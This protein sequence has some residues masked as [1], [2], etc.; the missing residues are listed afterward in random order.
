MYLNLVSVSRTLD[1]E[2]IEALSL[3]MVESITTLERHLKGQYATQAYIREAMGWTFQNLSQR[4]I[5]F[6]TA[7]VPESESERY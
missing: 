7:S 5:D 6:V 4:G 1:A 3:G 2:A